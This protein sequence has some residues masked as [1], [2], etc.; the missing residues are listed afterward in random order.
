MSEKLIRVGLSTICFSIDGLGETYEKLRGADY[1]TTERNVLQ[2]LELKQGMR[3]DLR[4]EINYVVSEI[5][6]PDVQEFRRVWG[7]RVDYITFQPMLTYETIPRTR[8]CRELWKGTLVVLWDGTVVACC[9]DYDGRLVV[10]N[11]TRQNVTKL[12]NGHE[13]VR[14]RRDHASGRFRSICCMCSEY[15]TSRTDGRFDGRLANQ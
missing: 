4:V 3:P 1:E 13:M 12:L 5:T 7:P 15:E 9:V 14:L 10:G 11:A 6:E 8:P 2:F